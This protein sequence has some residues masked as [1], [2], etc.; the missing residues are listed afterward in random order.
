M[1]PVIIAQFD[2]NDREVIRV[3]LDQYNGR[4]TIDMRSWWRDSAGEFKPGR[5]GLTLSI[6]HIHSL[7]DGLASALQRAQALGLV[8][9]DHDDEGTD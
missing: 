6:K 8:D 4:H 9:G 5:S 3:S 2:R 7:A 1:F